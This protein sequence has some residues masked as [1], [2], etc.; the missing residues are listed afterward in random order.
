MELFWRECAALWNYH[1]AIPPVKVGPL[2]GTIVQIGN[3]HI[4]PVNVSSFNID[5]Y[6]I[7]MSTVCYDGLH[8]GA[9]CIQ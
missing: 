2:D 6:A 4:G 7:R 3:T 5:Y 1:P 8:V 9:V